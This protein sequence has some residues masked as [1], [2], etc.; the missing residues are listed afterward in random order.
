MA[1]RAEIEYGQAPEAEGYMLVLVEPVIVRSAMHE[2]IARVARERERRLLS[3]LSKLEGGDLLKTLR[4]LN[5]RVPNVNDV[6][7]RA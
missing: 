5:D 1:C 6:A 3:G 7:K 4:R 2:R